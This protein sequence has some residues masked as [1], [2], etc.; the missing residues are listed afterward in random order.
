MA[1]KEKGI[2]EVIPL[3]HIEDDLIILKD[4][5]AA[6]GYAF[7]GAPF[8]RLLA[9]DYESFCKIFE[10]A[11]SVLPTNYIVQKLDVYYNTESR[12]SGQHKEGFFENEVTKYF[13]QRPVLKQV[14]YIF[15]ISNSNFKGG[16]NPINTSLVLGGKINEKDLKGIGERKIL[17]AQHGKAFI[18][19]LISTRYVK[20]KRLNSVDLRNIYYQ[21]LNLEFDRVNEPYKQLLNNHNALSL[22]EKRVNII[23][24]ESQGS[25]IFYSESND[26]GVE[27]PYTWRLGLNL[28]IPHITSMNWYIE[29]TNQ[30]ISEQKKKKRINSAFAKI[31]GADAEVKAQ[32][33]EDYIIESLD[34]QKK[35]TKLSIQVLAY[36]ISEAARERNVQLVADAFRQTYGARPLVETFDGASLFYSFLPGAAANNVRRLLL[37]TDHAS[38]YFNPTSE[39]YSKSSGDYIADRFRNLVYINLYNRDLNNQNSITIGPPGSGKSFSQGHFI[40]QRYERK[41]R[42]IIIDVGGTYRNIFEALQDSEKKP[43]IKYFE[44][45]PEKPIQFNPF[46]C[47]QNERGEFQIS[48]DKITFIITLLGLIN[49]NKSEG[50]NNQEWAV[51]QNFIPSYYK[52]FNERKK[53]D[54]VPRLD[55]FSKWLTDF[56]EQNKNDVGFQKMLERFDLFGFQLTLEP[57]VK[58]KYKDLLNS[59]DPLDISDYRLVCFDMA[60][61]KD[62]ER[63]Y[64]LVSS[65]LI[66]ITLDVVRK[67]K[68]DIKHFVMDE[69][70]SMLTES[71][72][73]FVMYMYRTIRKNKGSMNIVTQGVE[74]LDSYIGR[75]IINNAETKIILNHSNLD[76]IKK[77]G[78]ALGFTSNEMQKIASI[79]V[80]HDCRELFI[81]QGMHS[82]VFVLEVPPAEHAILTSEPNER[83]HLNKLK[84]IYNRIDFAVKQWEEDKR[85]NVI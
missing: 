22:G 18:E 45:S 49:K 16:S 71:M 10:S 50:W 9:Q 57:F 46:L 76:A 15:I 65:L 5:R 25:D 1:T 21:F 55:D 53:G 61:I 19:T 27:S 29:D 37:A 47:E 60:R 74:E 17:V 41:E 59:N 83:N 84:S 70:W 40:L 44:Y 58:G 78:L 66:E 36:T 62:D 23:S 3:L 38:C 73:E 75:V 31:G 32:Q 13:A 8:E 79:R 14:S 51:L 80:N 69:A 52:E 43:D 85:N 63:I 20:A 72:G 48:E 7:E 35:F 42:Q 11:L 26:Y 30:V 2:M 28:Q 68:D 33:I 56:A 82:D 54:Q 67:F 4:G 39:F 34:K 77:V 24:M 81:K 64:T 6:V 12:G